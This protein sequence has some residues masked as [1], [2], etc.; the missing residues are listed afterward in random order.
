[1]YSRIQSDSM[2]LW[3]N[4]LL[5][6]HT[7]IRDFRSIRVQL[8]VHDS[9]SVREVRLRHRNLHTITH[10]SQNSN[11]EPTEQNVLRKITC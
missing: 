6:Y 3:S 7:T 9:T 2:R 1:M 8:H 10:L 11:F 4:F 5:W